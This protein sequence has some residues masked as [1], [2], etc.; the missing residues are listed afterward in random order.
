MPARARERSCP[1]ARSVRAW[2]PSL[3]DREGVTG[4]N[5]RRQLTRR[6]LNDHLRKVRVRTLI[7]QDDAV[8][9][10]EKFARQLAYGRDTDLILYTHCNA[11][12]DGN[13]NFPTIP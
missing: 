9:R 10:L 8:V 2:I 1:Q 11:S 13:P 6:M 3:A 7:Q 4:D 12:P 5:V